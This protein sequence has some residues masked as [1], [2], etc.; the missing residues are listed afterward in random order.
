MVAFKKSKYS[1]KLASIA[2][3]SSIVMRLYSIQL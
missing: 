1:D 3:V 2:I